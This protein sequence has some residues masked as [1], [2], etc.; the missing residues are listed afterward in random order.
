MPLA[1]DIPAAPT[2]MGLLRYPHWVWYASPTAY[3]E[4]TF[5]AQ[6]YC[7]F[8]LVRTGRIALLVSQSPDTRDTP[9]RTSSFGEAASPLMPLILQEGQ[10]L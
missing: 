4:N 7:T 3:T 5:G 10:C 2:L 1:S 8:Y 9:T 6:G